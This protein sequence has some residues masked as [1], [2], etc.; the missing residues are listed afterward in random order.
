MSI[1]NYALLFFDE[2]KEQKWKIKCSIFARFFRRNNQRIITSAKYGFILFDNI[3][4]LSTYQRKVDFDIN[5]FL[6]ALEKFD[7]N[8]PNDNEQLRF[9]YFYD[10][11]EGKEDVTPALNGTGIDFVLVKKRFL[12]LSDLPDILNNKKGVYYF[13]KC[14]CPEVVSKVSERMLFRKK[15]LENIDFYKKYIDELPEEQKF[16][17][18][19]FYGI[20]MEKLTVSEIANKIDKKVSYVIRKV[21]EI[22]RLIVLKKL[23]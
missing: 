3:E 13:K 19:A 12:L 6:Y 11:V 21:D 16:I 23:V 7:G 22:T 8:K 5:K 15:F 4:T 20:D 9:R 17:A 1:F 10:I 2:E 18:K 14:V